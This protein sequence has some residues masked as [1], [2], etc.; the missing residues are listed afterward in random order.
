VSTGTLVRAS[1]ASSILEH[2]TRALEQT[3]ARII[4]AAADETRTFV[5]HAAVFDSRTSIGNPLG[6]GWYEE[7][8]PGAFSKTIDESDARFLVDHDSRMLVARKSAGDLRLVE[9]S[10]GLSVDADLDEELSYVRDLAR[11]LEKRRITGMSVRV[12]RRPRRVVDDRGGDRRRRREEQPRGGRSAAPGGTADAGGV[13]GDVPR[14]RGHRRRPAVAGHRDPH[15]PR[16]ARPR[17]RLRPCLW[18]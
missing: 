18:G 8:A 11:N 6:W 7:I 5:G 1:G 10:V 4:R 16:A 15:R 14:L 3:D 12:L 13:G 2:R 9:D 17:H